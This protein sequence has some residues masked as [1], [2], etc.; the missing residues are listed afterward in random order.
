MPQHVH[1]GPAP[2]SLASTPWMYR[3]DQADPDAA[4]AWLND[5]T[6]DVTDQL[7][8]H[9]A[10]LLRGA[11]ATTPEAFEQLARCVAPDLKNDYMGTSPR[12][13]VTSHVFNASELP[14][15]YPIPQHCEMTFVKQ[16]PNRVI[17]GCLTAPRKHGETPLCD[18]RRVAEQ[19]RADVAKR[20]EDGGIRIIRNY[21]APGQRGGLWQLKPWVDM[22]GTT[23]HDAVIARCKEEGFE[24]TF[25]EGDRL[26]IL[27][28]HDAFKTHPE[29]G[30]RV[31]FNHVQVFHDSAGPSELRRIAKIRP[32]ARAFAAWAL[33]AAGVKAQRLTTDPLDQPM[34]ATYRDGSPIPD[35][36]IEHLRDVIWQNMVRIPWQAGDVIA[37]DNHSV[38][39]GRMPYFGPRRIVVAWS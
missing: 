35:A 38:S 31:W 32:S 2:G 16:P 13:A 5:A 12:N 8:T 21:A 26:R 27:S 15:F 19:L 9:G 10:I 30:E 1:R 7:R 14:G 25:L 24:A 33:A 36:D 17:F 34:H 3:F 39:H 22:F 6:E 18:F 37:I 11:G 4:A 20:F 23:D 29:T 28:H